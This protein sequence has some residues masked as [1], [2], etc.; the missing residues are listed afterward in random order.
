MPCV[1]IRLVRPFLMAAF[2]VMSTPAFATAQRTFVASTGNDANPCTLVAPCRGFAAAVA[3][4]LPGGEVIVL[5]SA[6]YGP[7]N[8]A[9]SVSIIA[10]P[11]VYAGI[12]VFAGNGIGMFGQ[13]AT[14][15]VVLRGLTIS[16][17]GGL[18]GITMQFGGGI[19]H[20]EDCVLEGF[21]AVGNSQAIYISNDA[22]A[23]VFISN[24]VVR[25]GRDGIGLAPRPAGRWPP[26]LI[27]SE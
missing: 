8:L 12:S 21:A 25:G 16:S 3:Q 19:L 5:D 2:V 10:P 6:G 22:A 18:N 7:V 20:I 9:Q 24:T 13:P 23:Q 17:Q 26:P 14:T 4:T 27:M 1:A 11:G 15:R